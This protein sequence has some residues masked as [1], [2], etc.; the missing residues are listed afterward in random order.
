MKASQATRIS[1]TDF[2]SAPMRSFHVTWMSF[3]LCFF[4]WF[5]IAPL[6]AV[7]R[8][9]FSLTPEQL[10]NIIIASVATTVFARIGI[11]TLC[12]RIGP[13]R[14]YAGLLTLGA[15]P[16]MGIGLAQDYMSFLL[17][18]LA[19]GGIGA[20]FV[21]TQY[22]TSRM[23]APTVVGTANATTA[24]WGNLGGGVAQLVMPL[25]FGAIVSLGID[26]ALGWRLTMLVPGVAMLVMAVVYL[27]CTQ[28]YPQGNHAELAALGRLPV[29]ARNTTGS[30][31]SALADSRVWCLFVVYGACFGVELTINNVAAIYF[32]DRFGLSLAMAGIIASLF[33]LMNLFA[34]TLGGHFGDTLGIRYGLRGRIY[35]LASMV[36]AEGIALM[37]FSRLSFLPVAVAMMLV[38]S[39]FVQMAEGA[40]FAVVPFINDKALGAT[41]GLVGAGGNIGAIAAGFLLRTEG[42]GIADA[43]LYMG[44]GVVVASI[45]ALAVRPTPEE[46]RSTE[47]LSD[48]VPA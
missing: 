44:V 33:G 9:E 4:G 30:L 28:D 21:I 43:L 19:I 24:G 34:R 15:V 39:L 27:R 5:G 8:E 1:L 48:V 22:H 10:G 26:S 40:T 11:G 42:V 47:R 29:K 41:S 7:V 13:R 14:A 46:R 3:F 2:R 25:L 6:M 12:D 37:A 36:L 45:F 17:F 32:H 31:K 20:S 16:V 23:F 38:F 18:R 35:F